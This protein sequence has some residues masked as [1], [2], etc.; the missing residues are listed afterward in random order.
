MV[1]PYKEQTALETRQKQSQTVLEKYYPYKVPVIIQRHHKS[2]ELPEM[3]KIK[4]LIPMDMNY[5]SLMIILRQNILECSP[6]MALFLTTSNGTILSS[7]DLIS[8]VYDEHKDEDDEFLYLFY[9]S[10]NTFG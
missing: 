2:E 8:K 5:S 6:S 7:Y 4:Y 1:N 10:E 3:K 9:C